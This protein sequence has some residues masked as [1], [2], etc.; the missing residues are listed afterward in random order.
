MGRHNHNGTRR[1]GG[2]GWQVWLAAAVGLLLLIAVV[3]SVVRSRQV[4][5]QAEQ[6]TG[7]RL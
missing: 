2:D 7:Q 1:R 4:V 3:A 6:A 5:R